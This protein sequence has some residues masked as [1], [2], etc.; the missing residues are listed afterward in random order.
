MSVETF[1]T[2]MLKACKTDKYMK[3]V[4]PANKRELFVETVL[5]W[6]MRKKRK[7]QMHEMVSLVQRFC[8]HSFKET[9]R[10]GNGRSFCIS[11]KCTK[12][13]ATQEKMPNLLKDVFSV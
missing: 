8:K 12:C 7:L 2:E 1:K 4:I 5:D 6:Y 9:G 10:K 13:G 11:E 3:K